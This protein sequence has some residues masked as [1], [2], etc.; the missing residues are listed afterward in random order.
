MTRCNMFISLAIKW[1]LFV[2]RSFF[3]FGMDLQ[4][5]KNVEYSARFSLEINLFER[6]LNRFHNESL[7][8]LGYCLRIYKI[9]EKQYKNTNIRMIASPNIFRINSV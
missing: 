8:S 4:P 3:N 9:G 1:K 5:I 6:L 2:G 7:H